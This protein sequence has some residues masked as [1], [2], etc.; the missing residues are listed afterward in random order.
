MGEVVKKG[1]R[2]L[3]MVQIQCTHEYKQKKILV[4]AICPMGRGRNKREWWRG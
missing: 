2:R 3:N 1:C 4:E